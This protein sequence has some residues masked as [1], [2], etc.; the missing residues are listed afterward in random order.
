MSTSMVKVSELIM[1]YTLYPRKEIDATN[2][3]AIVAA[4]EA[5]QVLPPIIADADSLRIIDG[6]HRT[7]AYL[8]VFG[9]EHEVE[10]ELRKYDDER[11]MWRD[12][13]AYNAK[14]GRRLSPLDIAIV[15]S[16]NRQSFN[17][18]EGDLADALGVT[19]ERLEQ[20]IARRFAANSDEPLK[21]VYKELAGKRITKKQKKANEEAGG[22]WSQV[23]LLNQVV[24]LLESDTVNLDDERVVSRLIE[25]RGLIDSKV[26]AS[27]VA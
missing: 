22:F 3:S 2:R 10:V 5:G 20:V 16:R 21:G 6:F 7:A 19:T 18:D 26:G 24:A 15:I 12:A 4:L 13:I 25:I 14:H 17:L 1:D 11:E 9:P 27:C 23:A 8:Q